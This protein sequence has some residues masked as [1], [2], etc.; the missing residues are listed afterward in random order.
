MGPDHLARLNNSPDTSYLKFCRFITFVG[1]KHW[2]EPHA[3]ANRVPTG[4]NANSRIYCLDSRLTD[5]CTITGVY[6]PSQ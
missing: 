3:A 5:V 2:P 1:P 4:L 6:S